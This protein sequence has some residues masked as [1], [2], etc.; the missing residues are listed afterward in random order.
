MN[1]SHALDDYHE[2]SYREGLEILKKLNID[3]VVSSVYPRRMLREHYPSDSS[4]EY[5]KLSLTIPLVHIV[6]EHMH[7]CNSIAN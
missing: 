5:Y 3:I 6:L 2:K 7:L 4:C 1:V